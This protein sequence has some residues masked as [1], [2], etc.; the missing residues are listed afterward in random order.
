ME[1]VDGTYANKGQANVCQSQ[2]NGHLTSGHTYVQLFFDM[3]MLMCCTPYNPPNEL[4]TRETG[5]P[6]VWVD[7]GGGVLGGRL[8]NKI[9]PDVS[10][11]LWL[12]K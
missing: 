12:I 11:L 2:A 10:K 6:Y 1:R 4:D 8:G 5:H 3:C 9:G 7:K